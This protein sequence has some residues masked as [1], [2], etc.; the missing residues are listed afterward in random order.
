LQAKRAPT[1]PPVQFLLAAAAN[2]FHAHQPPY[3][4]RFRNVRVGHTVAPDGKKQ[5]MLCGEFLPEQGKGQAEWTPFVTIKTSDYEQWLG[6]Q[7]ANF[8]QHSSII[9]EERKDLSLALQS[10]LDGLR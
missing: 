3:P 6:V 7:A 5:Y 4:A 1:N 9:W 2:D 10:L 8:F